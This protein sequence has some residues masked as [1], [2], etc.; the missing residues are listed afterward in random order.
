LKRIE[1][2]LDSDQIRFNCR[3][4]LFFQLLLIIIV[5]FSGCAGKNPHKIVVWHS[6]R[7]IERLVLKSVLSEFAPR[8]PQWEFTELFYDPETARSNFLISAMGGSGP[9]LFR[10]ANDNV[11]PMV[12]LG[13]IQPLDSFFSQATLDSFLTQP[14]AANT[15]FNG[16]LYQI[17]DQIGNHLC[18]V[19]NKALLT[20]PPQTVNQL[21]EIGK[22]LTIDRDQDGRIDQYALVWNYA[23]PFFA[24]PFIGG[25]GGWII[26]EQYRPT[27]NT[28]A[29]AKAAALINEL[30]NVHKIIP[31]EC[32]YEISNALFKDGLAA[33]I[34]N[35]SWSWGTYIEAGIDIGLARIPQIDETGLWPTPAVQPMGYSLNANLEG[36]KLRVACALLAYLTSSET[37]LRFTSVSGTIP[38][39]ID[40]YKNPLVQDNP[41]VRASLEQLLVGRLTPPV[42]EL[43]WIW[44][45]MRPSYQAVFNGK[46]SPQQAAENMQLLAERLIRE[47]R[48]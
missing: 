39:R 48:E 25:Y 11:G 8:F 7:P 14:F 44:D 42:T 9:A 34:I 2:Q 24:V 41:L 29:V 40:A 17:A 13:V 38:S 10:G 45:A 22:K 12:E 28:E 37:Q 31:L 4:K 32:D 47:N 20:T 27:L 35:G 23:E 26:D 6:F 36:E 3:L 19:Y 5:I 21:I 1:K 33:M 16:R 43:R 18:L 30:A 15:Y 46:I